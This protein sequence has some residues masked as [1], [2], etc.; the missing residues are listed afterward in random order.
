MN[1]TIPALTEML[2]RQVT[3]LTAENEAIR[4]LMNCYNL[5]GWTDALEPMKRALKAEA[6]VAALKQDAARYRWLRTAGAWESEIGLDMLCVYPSA[7][8]AAVDAEMT[9]K[10]P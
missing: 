4:E 5:G 2:A 10:A 7:F 8:D 6:E 9:G 3:E 1:T